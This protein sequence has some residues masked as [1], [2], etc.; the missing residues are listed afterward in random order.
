MVSV[1]VKMLILVLNVILAIVIPMAAVHAT[2]MVHAHVT[3]LVPVDVKL[4]TQEE[5][6]S[7]AKAVITKEVMNVNFAIAIPGEELANPVTEMVYVHV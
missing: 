6:V 1:V 3:L 5:N 4:D 7:P 2:M